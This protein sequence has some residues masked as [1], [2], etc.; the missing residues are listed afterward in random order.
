MLKT[1]IAES[2]K[3]EFCRRNLKQEKLIIIIGDVEIKINKEVERCN[4]I[5]AKEFWEIQD[6]KRK[7]ELELQE[8]REK[9]RRIEK[10]YDKSKMHS[11]LKG[12]SFQNFKITK[13][14]EKAYCKAKEYAQLIKNGE[15]KSLIITGNIGTGKTHLASSIANFLIQSEI[16]PPILQAYQI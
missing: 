1:E 6:Y 10:L 5:Q 8:K 7:K 15:R 4:C 2:V 3:C 13:E 11:R 16:N 9:D 14:N 12:Y